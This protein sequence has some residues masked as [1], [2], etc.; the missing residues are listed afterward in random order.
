M[1]RGR[2]FLHY[3]NESDKFRHT[4]REQGGDSSFTSDEL[5]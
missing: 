3:I 5:L 4:Y 2:T 1:N